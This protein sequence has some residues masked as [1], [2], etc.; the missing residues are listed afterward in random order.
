M[1][2]IPQ[3]STVN[4]THEVL[5][6]G[7]VAFSQGEQVVVEQVLPNQQ[8]PEYKYVVVSAKLG[9][10]FQLSDADLAATQKAAKKKRL[11]RFE[12]PPNPTDKDIQA[13]IEMIKRESAK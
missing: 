1:P 4:I 8:Q 13:L 3:G 11:M 10:K 12:L 7:K 9:T 5:V 2:D 6:D